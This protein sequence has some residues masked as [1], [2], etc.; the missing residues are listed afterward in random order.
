MNEIDERIAELIVKLLNDDLGEAERLELNEWLESSMANKEK[1]EE[2]S[3]RDQ[4]KAGLEKFAS[5]D[6][7]AG[8]EKLR[9]HFDIEEAPLIPI[10][11][12]KKWWIPAAAAAILLLIAGFWFFDRVTPR[13]EREISQKERFKNDVTAPQTTRATLKLDDGRVIVLDN[14]GNGELAVQ[15]NSKVVKNGNVVRYN[16]VPASGKQ[17]PGYNTLTVPK[18]SKPVQLHLADGTEVWLDAATSITYPTAFTGKERKVEITG[19]GWFG[20]AHDEKMP[21]KVVAKGI[22]INDLGTEFNVKAFDD[23]DGVN[24]TLLQG[25]VKISQQSPIASQQSKTID[26]PGQQVQL[27]HDQLSVVN[28][29]DL[30]EVMAWK[31]GKFDFKGDKIDVIM[32]EV[33]RWYDVQV[34]YDSKPN[35]EFVAPI[36]R[37][38]PISKLLQLLELTGKVHFKIDGR[39][40]VVSN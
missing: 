33:A 23:E 18:G 5:Y 2:L 25:K 32:R 27:L 26:K 30:D 6:E 14:T 11:R 13:P 24:V 17:E 20:V 39:K 9:D 8:W 12:Q 15:G 38:V 36:S 10:T 21:F 22:E 4:L 3:N 31:N 35:D 37:N 40:V 28:G 19:Q 1:F 16:Q 29:V 7:E 34:M